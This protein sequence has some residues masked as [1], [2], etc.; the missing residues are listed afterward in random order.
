MKAC[1]FIL[2]GLALAA[3]ALSL[4]QEFIALH[5]STAHRLGLAFM[6]VEAPDAGGGS[7]LPARVISSPLQQATVAATQAGV[8]E[9]WAVAPGAVVAAGQLLGRVRSPE[10]LALQQAWLDARAEEALRSAALRR[11]QQLLDEGVIAASRLQQTGREALA[12]Q[13]ALQTSTAQLRA[14]GFDTAAMTALAQNGA[15][16]GYLRVLAPQA[17]TI[18]HL[19]VLPGAAVAAGTALVALVSEQLWLEAAVPARLAAA[20]SEGQNLQV[21]GSA[22]PLLLRQ[23]DQAIDVATQT[24][25]ILAEFQGATPF[26]PGQLVTLRLPAGDGGVLVP[27]DAVVRTGADTIVYVRQRDGVEARSLE[28]RVHGSDYLAGAGIT[29]GEEVVVRGAALLK[30]IQLGLGGE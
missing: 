26:L 3:P 7:A 1:R 5:A 13:A 18:A 28:L 21:D 10:V 30:G 11:D 17:G 22:T 15:D 19:Q 14:A 8:L 2:L 23:R 16:L 4:A 29:A 25:G 24:I 12:A 9:N 20:L 27:A 6:R